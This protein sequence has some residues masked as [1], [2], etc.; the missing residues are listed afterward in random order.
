MCFSRLRA[1]IEAGIAG[2]K[3]GASA[4]YRVVYNFKYNKKAKTLEEECSAVPSAWMLVRDSI[5]LLMWP[6]NNV[7]SRVL[8]NPKPPAKTWDA[9][10]VF[11]PVTS[12][13]GKI[14]NFATFQAADDFGTAHAEQA[15]IRYSTDCGEDSDSDALYESSDGEDDITVLEHVP[16]ASAV[17]KEGVSTRQGG[18]AE[19]EGRYQASC[20]PSDIGLNDSDEPTETHNVRLINNVVSVYVN[21]LMIYVPVL[22]T[23]TAHTHRELEPSSCPSWSVKNSTSRQT[24]SGYRRRRPDPEATKRGGCPEGD[25]PIF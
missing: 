11:A 9:F 21:P 10:I 2:A 14:Y 18:K 5:V 16:A 19:G 22:A 24:R 15:N 13:S 23:K 6:K 20:I 8:E 12:R 4:G 17:Q 7:T 1:E 3:S 25:V